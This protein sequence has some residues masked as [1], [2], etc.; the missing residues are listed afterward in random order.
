LKFTE[1]GR[2]E[3]S[4]SLVRTEAGI[5]RLRFCVQDS[6]IGIDD[7]TQRKLFQKFTQ[8]D[9]STTRRYGGTGLGLAISQSLVRAMGGEIE[10]ESARDQGS[11]FHFDLPI[12]GPK[13][14]AAVPEIPRPGPGAQRGRVLVIEDDWGNQ[15]VIEMF[16][17]RAGF[18][19]VLVDNGEKGAQRAT[20]EAWAAVLMDLQMPGIDGLETTRRIRRLLAGRRLPII[21]LTANVRSADRA[22][23]AAAGMDDFLT[24]PVR[25]TELLEC[26][27]R[28]SKASA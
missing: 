13:G 20:D 24:K 27:G 7:A 18:E 10:V 14:T 15:R 3:V 21:A 26:L 17:R 25:R 11:R 16:L 2:V 22:A 19:P 9:S 8:G 4:F 6:G 5:P 23:A 28:W 12:A 1:R